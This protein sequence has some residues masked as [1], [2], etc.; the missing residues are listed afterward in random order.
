MASEDRQHFE[1]PAC[2]PEY[3]EP[4]GDRASATDRPVPR[5]RAARLPATPSDA[6][7]P[8]RHRQE[9]NRQRGPKVGVRRRALH[10]FSRAGRLY[11]QRW[12]RVLREALR[13]R[14]GGQPST[15]S[16]HPVCWRCPAGRTGHFTG[17]E[18]M[19]QG[20]CDRRVAGSSAKPR[21]DGGWQC[22]RLLVAS[23]V[24]TDVACRDTYGSD[25]YARTSDSGDPYAWRCYR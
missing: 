2:S 10:W 14:E 20:Y 22:A 23:A 15:V 24:D 18:N 9:L 19:V 16:A 1:R 5:V 17:I 25:A 11:D 6:S 3:R 12:H 8:A 7:A 21:N 13:L 4:S